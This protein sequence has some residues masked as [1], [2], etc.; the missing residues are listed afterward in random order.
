MTPKDLKRCTEI[1]QNVREHGGTATE[2]YL[3]LLIDA[4]IAELADECSYNQ[5]QFLV[6]HRRGRTALRSAV[7]HNSCLRRRLGQLKTLGDMRV[8][9]QT[10]GDDTRIAVRNAPLPA[11]YE[12]HCDG[13]VLIELEFPG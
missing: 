11:V 1:A 13:Q 4:L 2:N 8:L 3:V 6:K 7:F 9:A 5:K 10:Y 12:L